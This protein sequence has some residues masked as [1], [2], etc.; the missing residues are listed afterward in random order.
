[1]SGNYGSDGGVV[2]QDGILF[3]A[4]GEK[5]GTLVGVLLD[6]GTWE[7]YDKYGGVFAPNFTGVPA[8]SDYIE[9]EVA[10]IENNTTPADPTIQCFVRDKILDEP[11]NAA[12]STSGKG[13][14]SRR[15][16]TIAQFANEGNLGSAD[17]GFH[18]LV[19]FDTDGVPEVAGEFAQ[20]NITTIVVNE[21]SANGDLTVW[22]GNVFYPT[23]YPD[24][25]AGKY[26][27]TAK[28]VNSY[29]AT[30]YPDYEWLAIASKNGQYSLDRED[31]IP[32]VTGG[33]ASGTRDVFELDPSQKGQ[34]MRF[35]YAHG[36]KGNHSQ[37]NIQMELTY[38]DGTSATIALTNFIHQKGAVSGHSIREQ[39][40]L[41]FNTDTSEWSLD[42]TVLSGVIAGARN[43]TQLPCSRQPIAFDA[44][45][46]A[47]T[48]SFS[49]MFG[50]N[51]DVANF[52][53]SID[54]GRNW[55]S[56]PSF[57]LSGS[58]SREILPMVRDS[59]GQ[60][61]CVKSISEWINCS[62][63]SWSADLIT[64]DNNDTSYDDGA[65][66][67]GFNVVYSTE[68]GNQLE[69]KTTSPLTWTI[70]KV[71]HDASYLYHGYT[72]TDNNTSSEAPLA[73]ILTSTVLGQQYVVA[74]NP[75]DYYIGTPSNDITF[76]A[77]IIDVTNGAVLGN[78][79]Y[80]WG[81]NT[82]VNLTNENFD[83][84]G[85][86][87]PVKLEFRTATSAISGDWW[88]NLPNA[89]LTATSIRKTAGGGWNTRISSGKGK[90]VGQGEIVF[91]FKADRTGGANTGM[92]GL[93]SDYTGTS[94]SGGDYTFYCHAA[95][96]CTLYEDG[97]NKAINGACNTNS[98]FQIKI[99]NLGVVTYWIDGALRYTSATNAGVG[100]RYWISSF[101][102]TTNTG[103]NSITWNGNEDIDL[104]DA[105]GHYARIDNIRL[106]EGLY[107]DSTHH[108]KIVGNDIFFR[109]INGVAVATFD[110]HSYATDVTVRPKFNLIKY[111]TWDDD[112][113]IVLS[114]QINSTG[115][116]I[117]MLDHSGNF[118][119]ANELYL[120][121]FTY[122]KNID[123]DA[124]DTIRYKVEVY[125]N[126]VGNSGVYLREV[127][128]TV[129]C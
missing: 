98:V 84:V 118:D 32:V 20:A 107:S 22:E 69:S 54:A 124:N 33:G 9:W 112:K 91:T 11:T 97:A 58:N 123:I 96:A 2:S 47:G 120:S 45:I 100:K 122:G 117:V 4:A 110:P 68:L 60:V 88:G 75:Y 90:T 44:Y 56:A 13:Y 114:Y 102:Y 128:D 94:Y 82:A 8:T 46:N 121:P 25:A 127:S 129:I 41:Q 78:K 12:A 64:P 109:N 5:I 116:W 51:N 18:S 80:T 29:S 103:I 17:S 113:R 77:K 85:N 61:S 38:E 59:D 86:G 36:D 57:A 95:N 89:T 48:V 52:E 106:F 62:S 23:R 15:A 10:S 40:V 21:T 108:A 72:F 27:A 119:A 105:T 92:H 79:T 42:G 26:V 50:G 35:A 66:D 99:S 87:H 43:M 71:A 126:A 115:A 16:Y 101:P 6:D 49:S 63:G 76:T 125:G 30:N 93:D 31:L 70:D 111:G 65:N 3:N 81:G 67:R 19:K 28:L 73:P 39:E 37:T 1:M 34:W 14:I 24:T 7:Y 74:F 55:Q 104:P 53:Y 83:F